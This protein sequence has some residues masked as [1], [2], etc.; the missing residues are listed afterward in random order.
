MLHDVIGRRETGKT[1]L[2]VFLVRQPATGRRLIFDPRNGIYP[3]G[4]GL[5]VESAAELADDAYPMFLAGETHE[6]IYTPRENNLRDAFHA[7]SLLVQHCIQTN[8]SLG[9]GVLVDECALVKDDLESM[10]HPFQASVRWCQRDRVHVYLTCHQPK[11]IPTNTRAITDYLIFFH[12]TQEHDLR[13]IAQR[14][15]E[16]FAERVSKLKPHRFLIW[17]D[18]IGRPVASVIE[19]GGWVVDLTEQPAAERPGPTVSRPA[20]VD[21]GNLWR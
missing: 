21:Y 8:P 2:A 3:R 18:K 11:D 19:P 14:C 20:D 16:E 5:K 10:D 6:V 15:S 9:L 7:W 13:V 4:D 1:T 12:C 17:D